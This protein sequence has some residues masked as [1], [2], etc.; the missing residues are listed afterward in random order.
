M[1]KATPFDEN[2][3]GR[4]LLSETFV[5]SNRSR[6]VFAKFHVLLAQPRYQEPGIIAYY[7]AHPDFE[8]YLGD[9][10]NSPYYEPYWN[11][12]GMYFKRKENQD[13]V[14]EADFEFRQFIRDIDAMMIADIGLST[15]DV[16]DYDWAAEYE[17]ECS[18]KESYD[19]WKL[20]CMP[21]FN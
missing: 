1:S 15:S 7:G 3:L 18:P 2:R 13:E 8:P 5:T 4:V 6:D 10:K 19:E 20:L 17:S 11:D 14:P 9:A 12:D 16:E 21:E